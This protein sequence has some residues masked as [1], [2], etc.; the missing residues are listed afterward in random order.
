MSAITDGLPLAYLDTL[1]VALADLMHQEA[2]IR[3]RFGGRTLAGTVDCTPGTTTFTGTGTEWLAGVEDSLR[4]GD[5]LVAG[6]Q[7]VKVLSVTS[8]TLLEIEAPPPPATE[9]GHFSGLADATIHK[10]ATW[11]RA[12][13]PHLPVPLAP[14][15]WTVSPIAQ[16]PH[17][18][19]PGH[20]ISSP[21]LQW[22]GVYEEGADANLLAD[23][24]AS[25]AAMAALAER[26]V[27]ADEKSQTL[28][29][30]R[31]DTTVLVQGQPADKST[32]LVRQILDHEL[33]PFDVGLPDSNRFLTA[34]SAIFSFEGNDPGTLIPQRW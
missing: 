27:F 14:P 17:K 15:Y 19:G 16:P 26:V 1:T 12:G 5:R 31:F 20:R 13:F 9:P 10:A 32:R 22:T 21:A 28:Q 24:Q 30:P 8:D 25:W 29:V 11:G 3:N 23:G 33:L 2:E 34:A 6:P 4:S 18:V 7:L